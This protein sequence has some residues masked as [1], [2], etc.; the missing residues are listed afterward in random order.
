MIRGP[1]LPQV[2]ERLW[3][4]VAPRLEVIERGLE[5]ID[6][7]FDCSNGQL[8]PVDCLA[9][10]A[11]G[12][13]VLVLLAVE[14][15][16]L[17]A[18]R[19]LGA[20]E[21]L[22]RVGGALAAALPEARLVPGARG[23]VLVIG[24]EAS[25]SA[26]GSLRRVRSPELQICMLEPF[27]LAGEERFA[28]R[29][30]GARDGG[31]HPEQPEGGVRG[32]EFAV[33]AGHRPF[34]AALQRICER[35]DPEVCVEGERFARRITWRGHRLGE[36]AV[37]AEGLVGSVPGAE[38]IVIAEARDVRVFADRLLR[39][40]LAAR[41]LGPSGRSTAPT[42]PVREGVSPPSFS[43]R[44]SV[45]VG[46]QGSIRSTLA[47]ARLSPEEYSALGGLDG[48]SGPAAAA[49]GA[50]DDVVRIVSAQE[51]PWPPSAAAD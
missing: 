33:P 51:G 26:L 31:S 44:A 14:G 48:E 7:T 49:A 17:L 35:L 22:E 2:R 20:L 16:V 37:R 24:T 32:E 40:Y 39:G 18:A 42:T 11:L 45:R 25:T 10:D 9:R 1:V 28:V 27:R 50:A 23:R 13:P 46:S 15:D 5:R 41:D 6:E 30:T 12:A 47:A 29:W 8:G 34:W 43:T 36:V 21:F 4:V 19:A 3:A 38:D